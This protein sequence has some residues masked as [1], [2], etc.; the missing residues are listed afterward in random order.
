MKKTCLCRIQMFILG[1]GLII[2]YLLLFGILLLILSATGSME[3]DEARFSYFLGAMIAIVICTPVIIWGLGTLSFLQDH[4]EY[5][6]SLI[7]R[8]KFMRYDEITQVYFDFCFHHLSWRS[9][10][11]KRIYIMQKKEIRFQVDMNFSVV[12]QLILLVP[13]EKIRV[14]F[15][16]E[17]LRGFPK[18]YRDLLEPV[19]KPHQRRKMIEHMKGRR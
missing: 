5:K 9:G 2:E 11:P 19:L 3:A 15:N 16:E 17:T 1:T 7:A 4:L 18:R 6:G 14:Y 10:V 12:K 8:R 13:K